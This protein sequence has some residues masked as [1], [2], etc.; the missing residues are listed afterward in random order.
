LFFNTNSK[1]EDIV[2]LYILEEAPLAKIVAELKEVPTLTFSL[3]ALQKEERITP[4][5]S[6]FIFYD[7]GC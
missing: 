2:E 3:S 6:A 7:R 1:D 5:M 4:V